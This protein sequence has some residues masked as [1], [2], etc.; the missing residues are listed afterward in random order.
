MFR[1]HSLWG[2][3]QPQVQPVT[4]S[5]LNLG[6]SASFLFK[7]NSSEQILCK[8]LCIEDFQTP[9]KTKTYKVLYDIISFFLTILTTCSWHTF[10]SFPGSKIIHLTGK[11]L[12]VVFTI[13]NKEL[14][15]NNFCQ[16]NRSVFN[17]FWDLIA[18]H[19]QRK[20]NFFLKETY[21]PTQW[22]IKWKIR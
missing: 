3:A 8:N 18:L 13:T 15:Q 2:K 10:F 16:V 20:L 7:S 4:N 11:D 5:C 17:I 19:S 12:P 9:L 6:S 14:N 22:R 1:D 21:N